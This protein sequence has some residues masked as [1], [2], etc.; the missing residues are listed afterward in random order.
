MTTEMEED[1]NDDQKFGD[2][3]DKRPNMNEIRR[4]DGDQ[5]RI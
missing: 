3:S 4:M 1:A 2:F 5:R